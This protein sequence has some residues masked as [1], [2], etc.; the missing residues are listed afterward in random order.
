MQQTEVY[1]SKHQS[2]VIYL[3]IFVTI[4]EQLTKQ[5]NQYFHSTELSG[6]FG[7]EENACP[8]PI[9]RMAVI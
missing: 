5:Q 2:A 7:F 4:N 1:C 8:E 3:F 6:N 9:V